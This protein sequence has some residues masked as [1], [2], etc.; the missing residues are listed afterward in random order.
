MKFLSFLKELLRDT[1]RELSVVERM[2]LDAAEGQ[3]DR[4][5]RLRVVRSGAFRRYC[6]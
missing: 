2:Y 5:Q 3:E 4:S 1:S 6:Y